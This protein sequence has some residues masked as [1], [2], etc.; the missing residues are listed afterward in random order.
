MGLFLACLWLYTRNNTFPLD[1]HPDEPGKVRQLIS[2]SRNF[3][4]PQLLLETTNLW[5][6]ISGA[7][8]N[9]TSVVLAGRQVS[10]MFGAAAVTMFA[11]TAYLTAGWWALACGAIVL[12]L[13]PVILTYSHYMK[14][15]TSLL[16]GLA[17][18]VL[19]SRIIWMTRRW[20]ARFPA[21]CLIAAGTALAISGKYV[22]TMVIALPLALVFLAPGFKW[23]RPILRL[24]LVVPLIL[25]L[26]G[27]INHRALDGGQLS[28]LGVIEH[29]SQWRLM[30][31][32]DFLSGLAVE[33]EHSRGNHWG[34]T[35]NQ[36]NSYAVRTAIAHAWPHAM[37][38]VAALPLVLWLSWRRGWGYE[39]LLVGFTA[40]CALVLSYSII[41]FPRYAMPISALLSL[42]AAISLGR[43][44]AAS[45]DRPITNASLG[46]FAILALGAA[47][48]PTCMDYTSQF[49]HDSR[50]ALSQWATKN[51]PPNARV[52]ADY[53][54][55]LTF[56]DSQFAR[57]RR[58]VLVRTAFI[59]PQMPGFEYQVGRF[60]AYYVICD[61]SYK[62]YFEPSVRPA[63]GH[64]DGSA[65]AKAFYSRLLYQ[66]TPVWV[67]SPA[68]N[69][70]AFTN[71]EIRVYRL[72]PSDLGSA[73]TPP[74]PRRR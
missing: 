59:L 25:L 13:S 49:A 68:R 19:A 65:R 11:L 4:H 8:Q 67:S 10:A 71:P 37:I 47:L 14:E 17:L 69:M 9:E 18:A 58:D 54:A 15:D 63:P 64:E 30:F 46:I 74:Q 66:S 28:I 34:L 52:F 73:S 35:A 5:L 33:A 44:L 27:L 32:P 62:R 53:Y 22:G 20:Y 21:W 41:L 43:M 40:L 70:Y 7:A 61:L 24:L 39:L 16:V 1:F 42:L 60:D 56:P 23:Y 29:P 45:A 57:S 72:T 36:P 38:P 55:G 3:Y 26:L 12:G 2:D 31:N 51:I 50:V 6:K 48:L